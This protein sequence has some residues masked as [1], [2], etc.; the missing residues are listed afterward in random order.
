MGIGNWQTANRSNT[1]TTGASCEF[2]CVPE[3]PSLSLTLSV[4]IS[5]FLCESVT[6]AEAI[7]YMVSIRYRYTRVA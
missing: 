3:S 7:W 1:S 6:V 2:Q 5:V 4:S